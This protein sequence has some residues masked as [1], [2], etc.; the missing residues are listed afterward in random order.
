MTRRL[1]SMLKLVFASTLVAAATATTAQEPIRLG[2][3]TDRVGPAKPYAD[4]VTQGAVYAVRELNAKG[5]L[6]GRRVELLIE[7]D[8]GRP[9]I[10]A[11][12][13][14][15]L[16]DAN[17][18]FIL[19]V[20]LTP[21]TLQAQSVT[22]ETRTPHITPSN[23]GDTLTTAIDNPNF[24]QT[25]PLGSTQIATLLSYAREK[26]FQRVALVTDNSDL[27]Q[28]TNRFFKAA[29]EKANIQIVAEE[30]VPRGSTTADPQ[31]QKVRAANPEALFMT[32]VLTPE[33]TL[34]LRSVRQLGL[35][36]PVLGNYNMSVPQYTQVARGLLDG[37]VFVD[38]F[39]PAKPEVKAFVEGFRKEMGAEPYN[40]NGYGYDGVMLVADAI[41]RAGG[42]DKDKV[43]EAMQATRGFVG[44]MGA[45]GSS[46]GFAD[47]RRTGFDPN[48]MVVRVYEGDQQGRV[49]HVGA[50]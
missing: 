45:V 6:L 22:K 41:R 15:K 11:T 36:V 5:G 25:G 38:A 35:R 23:S 9:D 10:S 42:T 12:A 32:G 47:G 19:S 8:Q 29:L 21:A 28:L 50:R 7:D 14:R 4:P 37:I 46:Y 26:K 33:N 48:G 3:I 44:V 20:S 24:W 34:I 30:V 39:D 17:V 43:R 1:L 49:V 18:A 16:V 2:L 40:L 13:A 31:M 27:G